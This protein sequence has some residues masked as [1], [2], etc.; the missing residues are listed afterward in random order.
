MRTLTEKYNA[1]LEGNFDKK[2]FVRDARLALPNLIT[3]YN[4]F[5]DT[6]AILKNRGMV[7]ENLE[8]YQE[9]KISDH[10]YTSNTEDM[11]SIEAV[12]RGVD[13]EL[14]KKGFNF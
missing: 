4:G 8:K 7:F 3:Q 10:E 5:E 6:V 13:Y 12:E 2:Q 14:E 1:V 9:E 11:F